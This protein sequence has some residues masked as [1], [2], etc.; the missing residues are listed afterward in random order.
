MTPET[1]AVVGK[2]KNETSVTMT[3]DPLH[4]AMGA[5]SKK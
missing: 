4:S 1:Y 5:T 2:F 3:L